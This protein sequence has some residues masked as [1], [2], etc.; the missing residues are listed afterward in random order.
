MKEM[1]PIIES[2]SPDLKYLEIIAFIHEQWEMLDEKSKQKYD[3]KN[4]P[5]NNND[6]EE[7]KNNFDLNKRDQKI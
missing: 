1:K 6:E 2:I 7:E 5:N 3:K 4:K